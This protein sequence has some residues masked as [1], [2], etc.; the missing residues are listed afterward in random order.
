[1][2]TPR[3][4]NDHLGRLKVSL[5]D[6]WQ[7]QRGMSR[8]DRARWEACESL[9][10]VAQL[11]AA[12]LRGEVASQPGYIG[13]SDV[14]GNLVRGLAEL[15]ARVNEAGFL[16]NSSQA[17]IVRGEWAQFAAVS[18]FATPDV[19]AR[20]R[21]LVERY[22]ELDL[23]VCRVT[24]GLDTNPVCPVTFRNGHPYTDFGQAMPEDDLR[25]D[26][27]GFGMCRPAA[28]EEIVAATQVAIC[29]RGA[30]RN[31]VLWRALAEFAGPDA[32]IWLVGLWT[33]GPGRPIP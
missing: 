21:E 32:H 1:M 7:L 26:W 22:P 5:V 20:L 13:P 9:A 4:L 16:T 28:V 8:A 2:I 23:T 33:R 6:W 24:P 30:G 15:L 29:D 19:L 12:W 10:D 11:T 18:G 14:D 17:G 3:K 31:E 25:D 27:T